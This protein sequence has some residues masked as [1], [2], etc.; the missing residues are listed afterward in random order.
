MGMAQMGQ[1]YGDQ[2][3]NSLTQAGAT[4]ENGLKQVTTMKELQSLSQNLSQISPESPDYQQKLM[5]LGAAHPFAMQDPRGQALISMGNQAHL[6]WQH[7]QYAMQAADRIANRQEAHDQRRDDAQMTI[8]KMRYGNNGGG[9]DFSNPAS[10]GLGRSSSAASPAPAPDF[11]EQVDVPSSFQSSPMTMGSAPDAPTVEAESDQP[12]KIGLG[13]RLTNPGIGS[14]D[15]GFSYSTGLKGTKVPEEES[16]KEDAGESGEEPDELNSEI[17]KI[18]GALQRANGG[19]PLPAN[20]GPH[21]AGLAIAS[22]KS[23]KSG[24]SGAGFGYK[25]EDDAISSIDGE[26]IG[27]GL[28]KSKTGNVLLP[29]QAANGKWHL[30]KPPADH[31]A[32]PDFDENGYGR[33]GN[34]LVRQDPNNPSDIKYVGTDSGKHGPVYTAKQKADMNLA[35]TNLANV[36]ARYDALSDKSTEKPRLA[37]ALKAAQDKYDEV[38]AAIDDGASKPSGGTNK[39]KSW[40]DIK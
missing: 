23:K 16:P 15:S 4:I 6:Q 13:G 25:T 3:V 26:P 18:G 21:I 34:R 32:L 31:S 5:Q 33:I 8:A 7:Q 9:L 38:F 12:M 19:R 24:A 10:V 40:K 2:L 17:Y 39:V 36:Q 28:V 35:Q 30:T 29:V 27:G 20:M 11:N 14:D 22:L 37:A 1:R